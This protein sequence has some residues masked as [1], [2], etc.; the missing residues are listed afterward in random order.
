M[1]KWAAS[2]PIRW[3]RERIGSLAWDITQKFV[4]ESLLLP[5]D[6]IRAA[7]LKLWKEFK[8][9][10]EPAAA[11]PLA[12][13]QQRKFGERVA[14][15]ICGA[16]LDA[17]NARLMELD[18]AAAR[19]CCWC[20]RSRRRTRSTA[21][22]RSKSASASN[23]THG[24]LRRTTP[25]SIWVNARGACSTGWR[26][27]NRVSRRWSTRT[28]GS[29]CWPGCCRWRRSCSAPALDRIG[30][31]QHVN[32]LSPPLLLFLAWNLLVYVA[33]GGRAAAAP[34]PQRPPP[35]AGALARWLA[36][37]PERAGQRMRFGLR[38]AVA[39]QFRLRWWRSAAAVE[40]WRLQQIL[41]ASAAAWGVGVALS[42]VVGGLVREYRVGWESTLLD[43]PQ[44]HAF[45]RVLFAP[46]VVLL[47]LD[48][49]SVADL[50]RMHFRSGVEIARAEAR[51]WVALYVA[52]LAVLVVLPRALL[53]L[54]ARWRARRAA[55]ALHVDLSDA[56][57]TGVLSRIGVRLVARFL[58]DAARDAEPV[59][60]RAAVAAAAGERG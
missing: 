1:W 60:D 47:P 15:V 44:V 56:Y 16:N 26:R 42:I 34:Q 19:R 5:E 39:A 2:R 58:L 36:A 13:L 23:R 21:S 59:A 20:R 55:E 7:Q 37:L 53:A 57:F 12:A 40:S 30:N 25:G 52:L 9:A 3:A 17:G 48:G 38:A 32:M 41:H 29:R 27:A 10:V 22:C 45:L 51:H 14:L 28:C 54:F 11:L 18:E 8:L 31:P 46:V 49:F 50:E 43:L 6:A 35:S 24:A 33:V 4:A